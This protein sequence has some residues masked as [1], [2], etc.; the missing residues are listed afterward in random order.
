MRRHIRTFT[1]RHEPSGQLLLHLKSGVWRGRSACRGRRAWHP[2]WVTHADRAARRDSR[3]AVW[4]AGQS[5][6]AADEH[7]RRLPGG[8]A[9]WRW[10]RHPVSRALGGRGGGGR[11]VDRAMLMLRVTHPPAGAV[12]LVATASP[13]QGTTLFVVVLLGCISLMALALAASLDTAAGSVP[14]QL[15]LTLRSAT[16]H[17]RSLDRD[18]ERIQAALKRGS[19]FAAHPLKQSRLEC[20]RHR[21]HLPV[22]AGRPWSARDARPAGRRRRRSASASAAFPAL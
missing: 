2:D 4:P 1:A 11:L 12:P 9:C 13:Y 14:A 6:R 8:E 7:F 20:L 5:A 17:F 15:E 3:A 19:G 10:R 16:V 18:L 22:G 21:H